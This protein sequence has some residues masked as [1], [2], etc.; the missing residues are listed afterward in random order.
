MSKAL[1]LIPIVHLFLAPGASEPEAERRWRDAFQPIIGALH[2]TPAIKVGLVLGGDLIE[3][4]Q[5]RHPEGIAWLRG[6]VER[7]QV[8]LLGTALHEPV[9]SAIPE[10]DGVGQLR[11]HAT[12]VKKVFGARPTGAWLPNGVWDPILPRVYR[13]AGFEWTVVDDTFLEA[14]GEPEREVEGV[15]RTEREGRS[16][17]LLPLDTRGRALA[18][19]G[20]VRKLIA[21]LRKRQAYG[22]SL[23]TLGLEAEAFGLRGDTDP[24]QL[25]AWFAT[26]LAA[27]AKTA[28]AIRTVLPSEALVHVEEQ[29]RVYLPSMAPEGMLSPW[30][31]YLARYDEANRLHKRMLRVSA[32]ISKL[33]RRIKA[34]P[35]AEDCP[36]PSQLVQAQR[37]LY[38]SQSA[39]VYWH[40]RHAGVYD[41]SLRFKA[42]RDLLRAERESLDALGQR[43][44]LTVEIADISCDGVGEVVLRTPTATAIIDPARSGGMTELSVYAASRNIMDALTRITE[45]YHTELR[46]Y[47]LAEDVD[48][49][50]VPRPRNLLADDEPTIHMKREDF[51]REHGGLLKLVGW[52]PDPRV[53]F[54]ERL[55]SPDV[56]LDDLRRGSYEEVGHGFHHR[57][58]TVVTAERHGDDALRAIVTAEGTVR[59]P[60]GERKARLHKRYTLHREPRL[61]VRLDM[62]NRSHEA[63]RTRLAWELNL[64]ID[65]DSSDDIIAVGDRRLVLDEEADLGEADRLAIE[66]DEIVLEVQLERPARIWMY[67]VQT[68]HRHQ[69]EQ[70]AGIQ[71]ICLLLNWPVELWG[72]EKARFKASLIIRSLGR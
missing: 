59:G 10:I 36:D 43:E 31:A 42:W 14:L 35:Y 41:P 63:L 65:A 64:S 20:P 44:R 67:P 16:L 6:L 26:F 62:I 34:D 39:A 2:H 1:N 3:D 7:G 13:K 61:D 9:L 15:Y 70:V 57:R 27:L 28:P 12:L 45:P 71:G 52:D 19:A 48:T 37:Y 38:R 49:D 17:A 33:E 23:A 53:C 72:Q 68:V 46:R 18:G 22:H 54:S 24:R 29:H 50:E 56:T 47:A 8:E 60:G 4:L 11:T 5:Q 25:Q 55:L 21:H 32:V 30:E 40:G 69:G 58:W 51:D 66:G